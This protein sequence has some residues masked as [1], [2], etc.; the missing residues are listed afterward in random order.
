MRELTERI[1]HV[2]G[3]DIPQ[4]RVTE[5]LGVVSESFQ[6]P[7]PHPTHFGRYAEIMQDEGKGILAMAEREQ[8]FR[9]ESDA[10]L[11]DAHVETVQTGNV[12][13]RRGQIMTFTILFVTLVAGVALVA[14]EKET[15]GFTSITIGIGTLIWSL[16]GP[17]RFQAQADDKPNSSTPKARQ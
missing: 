13:A 2:I 1:Q 15:A 9:H 3:H 7:L 11:V 16:Y 6:G 5:L 14:Y 4:D 12:M 8:A 17:K 10:K